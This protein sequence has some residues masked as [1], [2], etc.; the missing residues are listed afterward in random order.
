MTQDEHVVLALSAISVLLV[1]VNMILFWF[2][3]R[4]YR[5]RVKFYNFFACMQQMFGNVTMDVW[6]DTFSK[7]KDS[8]ISIFDVVLMLSTIPHERWEEPP[9]RSLPPDERAIALSLY[10]THLKEKLIDQSSDA[11]L[12]AVD[13]MK[14]AQ[15]FL[16]FQQGLPNEF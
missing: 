7:G 3:Y 13:K 4:S 12:N 15:D 10:K 6:I 5:D 11:S 9:S 2:V 1:G 16:K 8:K 14:E